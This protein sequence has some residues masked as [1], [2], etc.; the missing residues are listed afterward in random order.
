MS[1]HAPDAPATALE[2]PAPHRT[3]TR[4]PARQSPPRMGHN[5]MFRVRLKPPRSP[6][7]L[8]LVD[9]VAI[10]VVFVLIGLII[11]GSVNPMLPWAN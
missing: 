6:H 1:T 8:P 2:E 7:Q 4:L 9:G 3:V 10:T 11:S 5:Q